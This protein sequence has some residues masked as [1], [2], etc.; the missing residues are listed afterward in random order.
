LELS[1]VLNPEYEE[2][3]ALLHDIMSAI[4]LRDANTH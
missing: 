1:L 4:V 3:K 2:A